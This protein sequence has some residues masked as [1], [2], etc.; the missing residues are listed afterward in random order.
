MRKLFV[1]FLAVVCGLGLIAA[2][3]SIATK[4]GVAALLF[5]FADGTDTWA[6]ASSNADAG[7]T[8]QSI[9]NATNSAHS[10]QI[11]AIKDGWFGPADSTPQLP[12]Y[13]SEVTKLFFNITTTSE[14]TTQAIAVQVGS[15]Y[16]WCQTSWG[17]IDA[18]KT[19]TVTVD[20]SSLIASASE[21]GGTAPAD[22]RE[23]HGIWVY[24]SGGGTY[25]LNSVRV[26]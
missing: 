23:I 8:A 12:L 1:M 9:D 22:T 13:T 17:Y 26:Q 21:C 14:A 7:T 20:L 3:S 15:N 16:Q 5:D 10:L 18:N 11:D 6:A 4:D 19:T 24:F 2:Q 25:Y